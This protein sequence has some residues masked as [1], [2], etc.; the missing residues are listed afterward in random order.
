[1]PSS[2]PLNTSGNVVLDGSG[3]GIVTLGP[4]VGQRWQLNSAAVRTSTAT[5]FPTCKVYMGSGAT[6]DAEFVDGTYSGNQDSTDRVSGL[7]LGPNQ[8]ITAFWQGGDVGA[9]ATL[10]I[11]GTLETS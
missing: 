10:S 2:V 3:N 11:I 6:I 7:R 9:T 4:N 8:K 1:M 5:L